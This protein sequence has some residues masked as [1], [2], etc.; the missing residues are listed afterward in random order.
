MRTKPATQGEPGT[1]LFECT[2]SPSF[3]GFV[4]YYD[5]QPK[6]ITDPA[7]FIQYGYTFHTVGRSCSVTNILYAGAWNFFSQQ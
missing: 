6:N 2:I 7:M 5:E 1:N 3:D 4:I